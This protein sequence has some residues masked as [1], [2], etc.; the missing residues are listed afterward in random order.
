MIGVQGLGDRTG[1]FTE[2]IA[3]YGSAIVSFHDLRDAYRCLRHIRTDN[4]F[5]TRRLDTHFV[6]ILSLLEVPPPLPPNLTG[7][8]LGLI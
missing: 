7:V 1:I 6:S 8:S 5:A 4:F 3:S 2:M